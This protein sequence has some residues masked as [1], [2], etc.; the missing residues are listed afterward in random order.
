MGKTLSLF[1]KP[2]AKQVAEASKKLGGKVAL[3]P[4]LTKA[5]TGEVYV[6]TLG[7]RLVSA[8]ADELEFRGVRVLWG[9]GLERALLQNNRSFR[10]YRDSA[11]AV[12][13]GARLAV[14]L[15]VTG[16]VEHRVFSA[17]DREWALRIRLMA[18]ATDG[19]GGKARLN[20]RLTSGSDYVQLRKLFDRKSEIAVGDAAK[21]AE[22]SLINELRS[23]A[24]ALA[25]QIRRALGPGVL[26][27][28]MKAPVVLRPVTVEG[29]GIP[30]LVLQ[31]LGEL[32][33]Q[34][35]RE[36][37]TDLATKKRAAVER[38][39]LQLQN[40]AK[41]ADTLEQRL[42]KW[43]EADAKGGKALAQ[44]RSKREAAR[45]QASAVRG[46]LLKL[47][48][49]VGQAKAAF[50][51]SRKALMQGEEARARVRKLLEAAQSKGGKEGALLSKELQALEESIS[52]IRSLQKKVAMRFKAAEEAAAKARSAAS[53]EAKRLASIVESTL[54]KIP[55]MS[56]SSKPSKARS[57][58][59]AG[60][61][62]AGLFAYE[63]A[64]SQKDVLLEM[65][66][67]RSALANVLAERSKLLAIQSKGRKERLSDLRNSLASW[68]K[69]LQGLKAGLTNKGARLRALEAKLVKAQNLLGEAESEV[70]NLN[71]KI[72]TLAKGQD[73]LD[74][75]LTKALALADQVARAR[76]GAEE[77]LVQEKLR[78]PRAEAL[79]SGPLE[80]GGQRF[81]SL[82]EARMRI[83]ELRLRGIQEA[84]SGLRGQLLG[85]LQGALADQGLR[86]LV[87]EP[88]LKHAP[89]GGIVIQPSF[90]KV[91][92]RFEF[93]AHFV[94]ASVPGVRPS[95][96]L[97]PRWTPLLQEA[98]LGQRKPLQVRK[99]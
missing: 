95:V 91:G 32:V 80:L 99:K 17:I 8:L 44:L 10:S 71:E 38:I 4:P 88:S 85:L 19:S 42:S 34:R 12:A 54:K 16:K 79:A 60:G 46:D 30:L 39:Q 68:E 28:G 69:K 33:E 61:F 2:F 6:T 89:K 86:V 18:L 59:R 45:K 64:L 92:D 82:A 87:P 52:S 73:R 84:H 53:A 1:S 29:R 22:L 72:R 47:R 27:K 75:K 66:G 37:V 98:V 26:G 83:E 94:G 76:A 11:S 57:E 40:L 14:P 51:E 41:Q 81:E 65:A 93:A 36:T 3:F 49:K 67:I 9:A 15:V 96:P 70:R 23:R 58:A 77:A 25:V 97:D 7:E 62:G 35:Y 24:Q 13:L 48:M 74:P 21:A 50:A 55:G 31:G 90:K 5:E 56:P 78:D 20:K 43:K 63:K